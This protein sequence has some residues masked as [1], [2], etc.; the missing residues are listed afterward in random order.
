MRS[1]RL[2]LHT[3]RVVIVRISSLALI[4]AMGAL[5]AVPAAQAAGSGRQPDRFSR[6]AIA[7]RASARQLA[8][9]FARSSTLSASG[10]V[11]AGP[12]AESS[13]GVFSDPFGFR[14]A[15]VG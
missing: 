12:A 7:P 10:A 6:A 9:A 11:Q 15:L 14:S 5:I 2:T 13:L 3:P 8:A 1:P 4:S